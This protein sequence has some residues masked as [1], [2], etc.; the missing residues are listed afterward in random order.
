MDLNVIKQF[1]TENHLTFIGEGFDNIVYTNSS[2]E[3]VFRFPK[4]SD[5]LDVLR[6]ESIILP[7]LTPDA[8]N[9]L[10]PA[11]VIHENKGIVY[12]QYPFVEGRLYGELP[13]SEKQDFLIKLAV[14]LQRL[15]QINNP[16]FSQLPSVNGYERFK[17][18]FQKIENLGSVL[19]AE[20]MGYAKNLFQ[21]FLQQKGYERVRPVFVHGDV[22]LDHIYYN[23]GQIAVIDWSDFQ[24]TDPAYDFHHLLNELPREAHLT[25]QTHYNT[26]ADS[27]FWYRAYAYRFMD[28]FEVLLVFV[29][30]QNEEQVSSFLNEIS[31]DLVQWSKL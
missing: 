30:Q 14:F 1:A 18:V 13:S 8:C 31:S 29:E 23:N 28:T 12:G 27:S 5:G 19:G 26:G 17:K 10:V 25:L 7:Y 6:K 16:I 4:K 15:H 21:K 3:S 11:P 24:M 20:K 22:S 2:K 9:A